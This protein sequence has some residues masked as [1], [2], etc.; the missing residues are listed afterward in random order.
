MSYGISDRK[1]EVHFLILKIKDSGNLKHEA[2]FQL[3]I[4]QH[5]EL[6]FW[7]LAVPFVQ[8][9]KSI[10]FHLH[11]ERKMKHKSMIKKVKKMFNK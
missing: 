4:P 10:L 5:L 9:L 1:A 7:L 8:S 6:N 11:T 2:L 3:K